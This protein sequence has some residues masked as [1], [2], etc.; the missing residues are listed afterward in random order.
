MLRVFE[1][2]AQSLVAG[3]LLWLKG[4]NFR[5]WL[6]LAGR[7]VADSL[8]RPLFMAQPHNQTPTLRSERWV[9]ALELKALIPRTT[10]VLKAFRSFDPDCNSIT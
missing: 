9:T 1:E 6:R 2:S 3:D 5:R 7:S 10:R 8:M 4:N